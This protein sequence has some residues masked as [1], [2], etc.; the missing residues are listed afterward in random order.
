MTILRG[1][2]GTGRRS[3]PPQQPARPK[4]PTRPRAKADEPLE[5]DKRIKLISG[6]M[7]VRIYDCK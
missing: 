7:N 2:P 1:G 6:S 4:T 3:P 5:M